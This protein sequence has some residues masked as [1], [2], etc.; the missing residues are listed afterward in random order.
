MITTATYLSVQDLPSGF[1]FANKLKLKEI[2][3]ND[4]YKQGQIL[5]NEGSLPRGLYFV[6]S[7]KIKLFKHGSDGKEKIIRI[8]KPGDFIGYRG[9][10]ANARYNLSAS[11]IEDAM[12]TFIPKED[13]LRLFKE[14]GD[15]ALYF[16]T[17]LSHALTAA[18]QDIVDLAY[19][20]V[21]GRLA[22][23]LLQLN[24]V[25]DNQEAEA[26]KQGIRLSREDLANMIGTAKETVIRLLSEF[27]TENL[28][29]IKGRTI[30]VVD[31]NGLLRI[32]NLYN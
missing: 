19:K 28:I 13:F 4:F 10:L 27:K 32:N 25:F 5:F 18:E 22:E 31:Q 2:F 3:E 29:H 30:N 11:V 14:N 24:Q 1:A 15:V 16:T 8:A 21:R 9:L 23:A 6:Q 12:V 17:L 20:P 7:G 26:K